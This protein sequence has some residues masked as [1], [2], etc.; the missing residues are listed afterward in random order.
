LVNLWALSVLSW[1]KRFIRELLD[2]TVVNAFA[3]VPIRAYATSTLPWG[4][5]RVLPLFP[6]FLGFF[7]GG[8]SSITSSPRG[9]LRFG[10]SKATSD[11][12][13]S[14]KGLSEPLS[15]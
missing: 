6:S 1:V 7:S 14:N 12:K 8:C 9:Q 11:T 3:G 5:P 13:S 10:S 15:I 4:R 2:S